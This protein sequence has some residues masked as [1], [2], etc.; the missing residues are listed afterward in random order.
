MATAS[1]P[2]T[3][4]AAEG[5]NEDK[6]CIKKVP[7]AAMVLPKFPSASYKSRIAC[8]AEYLREASLICKQYAPKILMWNET[9]ANDGVLVMECPPDM[10]ALRHLLNSSAS[11]VEQMR[12]F[13]GGKFGFYLAHMA[14]YTSELALTCEKA[15]IVP[16]N[17]HRLW[18]LYVWPWP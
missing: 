16:F 9:L 14:F 13:V 5:G 1:V 3:I 4:Y 17:A 8:E 15:S 12:G 18:K 6:V 7:P 11:N 2:F 10:Q